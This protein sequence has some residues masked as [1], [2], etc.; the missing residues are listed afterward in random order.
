[1]L[2]GSQASN[3]ILATGRARPKTARACGCVLPAGAFTHTETQSACRFGCRAL[4]P[5][6][7]DLIVGRSSRCFALFRSL[8][9][10]LR[11]RHPTPHTPLPTS[12]SPV[13]P[14]PHSQ[15][16]MQQQSISKFFKAKRSAPLPPPNSPGVLLHSPHHQKSKQQ[17]PPSHP[18]SALASPGGGGKGAAASGGKVRL[19]CWVCSKGSRVGLVVG[20]GIE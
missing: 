1:M 18:P 16:A 7:L 10:R 5:Y 11:S 17:H 9:S 13:T 12:P 3:S 19:L 4:A 2:L 15:P 20:F 6:D 8:H 14:P